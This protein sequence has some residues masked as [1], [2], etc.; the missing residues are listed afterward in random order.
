[1]SPLC[2][3]KGIHA[4]EEWREYASNDDVSIER[5]RVSHEVIPFLERTLDRHLVEH[6][7]ALYAKRLTREHNL[8]LAIA[9]RRNASEEHFVGLWWKGNGDDEDSLHVQSERP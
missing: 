3:F 6:L 8:P 7:Y 1:M 9:V 5:N 4:K 2:F